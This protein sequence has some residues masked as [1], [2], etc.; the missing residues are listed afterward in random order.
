MMRADIQNRH[1]GTQ[2]ALRY[3]A[4]CVLK[5]PVKH[6]S[7]D[8]VVAGQ[9]PSAKRQPYRDRDAREPPHPPKEK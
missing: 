8:K 6:S 5:S 3:R 7:S 4:L 1:S 2:E 9:P